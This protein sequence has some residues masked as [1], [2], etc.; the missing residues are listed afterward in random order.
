MLLRCLQ[1]AG[2]ASTIALGAGVIADIATRSERG[3]FFGL[4]S[5]GPMVGP[6]LGPVIGGLLAD[7]LGWSFMPH[8]FYRPL[9]PI[10]GRSHTG[11]GDQEKP[12]KKPFVNPLRLFLSPAVSLLLLF[13]A[14][15]YAVFYGVTASI[16][17][18]F[19][20]TYPFLNETD[21]GLCFLA[22]GGGMLA[23]S[24]LSGKALD[25]EYQKV[26]KNLELKCR[27][28]PECKIKPEEVTK[29]ENFPIEYARFRTMP[30]YFA[31]YI[32]ACIAYGWCL[33]RK[34]N[35]AG[36]LILQVLIGYTIVT[37]MNTVQTLLVDLNPS[38]GSSVTACNN[39]VRCSF[40]AAC[41]SVID[42]MINALG[43]GWTYVVLAGLSLLV[44][45]IMLIIIKMG[46]KWRAKQRAKR[47]AG[48]SS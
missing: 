21:I 36:P 20:D 5:L 16:S 6:C 15:L 35:L 8:P 29:D 19:V 23:G 2:S 31:L 39:L 4:Y 41:V 18:L 42:L 38:Q 45:P 33:D 43:V 32:A 24:W 37:I 9:L 46:P 40:G 44:G 28:D 7:N 34:V 27:E 25:K 17:T 30:I 12:E 22:I 3:G 11:A 10:I 48:D 14:V 47:A 1:A 26:K 13:N